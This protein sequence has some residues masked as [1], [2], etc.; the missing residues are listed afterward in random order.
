M[1]ESEKSLSLTISNLT[2]EEVKELLKHVRRIE[3]RGPDRT[4]LCYIGGLEK[5]SAEEA[6]KILQEI[7]PHIGVAG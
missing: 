2:L 1:S 5:R 4:I 6:K 3:Q 7:F